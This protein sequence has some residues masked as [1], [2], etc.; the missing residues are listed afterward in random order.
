MSFMFKIS[1]RLAPLA[2]MAV[3]L[4]GSVALAPIAMAQDAET[5]PAAEDST[6]APEATDAPAV[7]PEAPAQPSPE[8]VVARIGE[9]T[10]TEADLGFAAEDLQQ[11]LSQMAPQER[12]AFLL[13]VLI[14]MKVMS[15]AARDEGM[16]Q[17]ELFQQR[18]TYLEERALRRAYFAEQIATAVTPEAIET[19]YADVV[20]DFEPEDEI[21]ARHIL[22]ETEEEA[23]ALSEEIEGGADFAALAT[24][25]SI[26]P[27]AANGG[28]LGFFSQGMMV[29]EFETA[30]FALEEVGDVSEPVQSQ[31]GWHIIKLEERRE[32]APPTVEQLGPQLQQQVLMNAFDSAVE[33]LMSDID[34]EIVDP[35]LAEAVE[36]QE[37][38]EQAAQDAMAAQ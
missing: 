15:Q 7:A 24:E 31:F 10:I 34:V 12:R 21:R 36:A 22:V 25:N 2:G 13:R 3:L 6:A 1:K 28:D 14:D 29:P 23:T 32:S 16:D 9:V 30:A 17:T 33:T 38:A 20:A 4:A 26:D 19:L 37:A 5:P 35:A 18:L 11:E 27:G 8:T